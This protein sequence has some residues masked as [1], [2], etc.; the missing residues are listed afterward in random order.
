[1][2]KRRLQRA[3]LIGVVFVVVMLGC[4]F[5]AV[6]YVRESEVRSCVASGGEVSWTE[7]NPFP[8]CGYI[9]P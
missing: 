6:V 3:A 9:F 5:G 8:K 7:G 2:M 4:Y 1:M